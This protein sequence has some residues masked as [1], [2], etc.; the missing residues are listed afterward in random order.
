MYRST[1]SGTRAL[2]EPPCFAILRIPDDETFI[3]GPR[4]TLRDVGGMRRY[5]FVEVLERPYTA[6]VAIVKMSL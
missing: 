3:L 1:C 6:N 4:R 5:R 2:I